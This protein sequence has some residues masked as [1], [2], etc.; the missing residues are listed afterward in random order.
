MNLYQ[1]VE[2]TE[3]FNHAG[4][5]A[6]ADIAQIAERLGFQKISISMDTTV[7]SKVGKLRRQA[8]Y[9]RDWKAAFK[10]IQEGSIVLLQHPFHHKQLTREKTLR[11]LKDEKQVRFLSL[12][13]D[14]EELRAF[15]YS[16]Y[17]ARE[18]RTMLDL[19]EYIIV[20]NQC[21]KQWFVGQGIGEA[22][23]IDL[24]IFDYLYPEK[25]K[26]Y[27]FSKSITVA[28]NLDTEKCGYIGQL[29]ELTDLPVDL[30][31]PNYNEA[32]NACGNITYHGSF[33]SDEVPYQLNKGFG[34]VWDGESIHGCQ[35]LSGQ[36]LRYNNPHKLSLYLASGL[37]VVIWEEAAEAGFVKEHQVGLC[38]SD[39]KELPE[40]LQN[41]S[42]TS[43]R[44]ICENV[45]QIREKLM[46][47][48]FAERA[49]K[50][51]L[52]RMNG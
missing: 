13:H 25:E 29:G 16:E 33:P 36:Y 12:V 32:L 5:K 14:V 34:L 9:L 19:A 11:R 47:G 24:Q 23:L 8:G 26:N 51:A 52:Q 45:G 6:T 50:E 3:N 48:W 42:E 43:C 21:M 49:L 31:G 4:T 1:I 18:F 40:A 28:G 27:V 46:G 22:K 44:K 7:D 20:H 30:Y 39:L 17:Y 38:V 37:P 35:G 2:I 10:E 41:L 15:R